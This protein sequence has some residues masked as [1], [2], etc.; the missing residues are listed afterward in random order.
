MGALP[1]RTRLHPISLAA[2]LTAVILTGCATA[3]AP[4]YSWDRFPR[5]QYDV[6]LHEGVSPLDQI[7]AM[8]AHAERARGQNASLPPGFRAHLG[9]LHLSVGNAD[10]ARDLWLAE[11]TAFPE[12]TPYMD[13][14]LKKLEGPG[15]T[16]AKG[17]PA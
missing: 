16:L 8:N 5:Q 14:L 11:K 12:S 9:M 1:V 4:L 6:L 2:A 15:R 17:N 7:A 13:S 10:A 3:P